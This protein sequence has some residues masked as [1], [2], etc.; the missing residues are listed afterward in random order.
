MFCAPEKLTR[1]K[2]PVNLTLPDDWRI[3]FK[4]DEQGRTAIPLMLESCQIR[5]LL[6]G[7]TI[8][9]IWM[10]DLRELGVYDGFNLSPAG[11][12]I[13]E[14]LKEKLHVVELN[15]YERDKTEMTTC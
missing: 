14:F 5:H 3:D 4:Y 8:P 1:H 12:V 9:D 2:W 11:L 15:I 6:T 10:E 7:A 13:V